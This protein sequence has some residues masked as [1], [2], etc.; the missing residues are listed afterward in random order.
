MRLS[1]F[2]LSL[3]LSLSISLSQ[4]AGKGVTTC[5]MHLC[6]SP[7]ANPSDK[8]F[9]SLFD[10]G[11]TLGSLPARG[12]QNSTVETLRFARDILER[13]AREYS[14]GVRAEMVKWVLA[15]PCVR[16]PLQPGSSAARARER[17]SVK[18]LPVPFSC[19]VVVVVV[20][21]FVLRPNRCDDD[22]AVFMFV[23]FA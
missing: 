6:V 16:Q 17:W 9:R 13:A 19:F 8:R 5:V 2:S 22:D 14:K 11:V 21:L 23:I 10:S 1:H 7:S 12:S 3:S 20:C 4:T 18:D 15:H